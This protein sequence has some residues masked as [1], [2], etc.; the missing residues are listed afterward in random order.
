MIRVGA[1]I[2]RK[3]ERE[4][5]VCSARTPIIERQLRRSEAFAS[6]H[7]LLSLNQGSAGRNL[8]GIGGDQSAMDRRV[9]TCQVRS[10]GIVT[11]QQL[12]IFH[13]AALPGLHPVDNNC[14]DGDRHWTSRHRR[15]HASAFAHP[16]GIAPLQQHCPSARAMPRNLSIRTARE[17]TSATTAIEPRSPRGS[18]TY[19]NHKFR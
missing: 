16:S 8:N 1:Q 17:R 2:S 4:R 15:G 14:G 7:R 6:V 11:A 19:S 12:D 9:P 10:G 18:Q 5:P 3:A 13:I